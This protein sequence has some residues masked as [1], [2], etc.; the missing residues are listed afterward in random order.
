MTFDD[1]YISRNDNIHGK[2]K[3]D[4]GDFNFKG[5]LKDDRSVKMI[6]IYEG[7]QIYLWGEMSEDRM[8]IVGQW[9]KEKGVAIGTFDMKNEM[10]MLA[11]TLGDAVNNLF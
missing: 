9:G 7:N 5:K 4:L 1:F 6:K 11:G 10:W 3:D 8:K 2:G